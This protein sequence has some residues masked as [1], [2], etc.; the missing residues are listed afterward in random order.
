MVGQ[1]ASHFQASTID[2]NP[3]KL[4]TDAVYRIFVAVFYDD[5]F[6]IFCGLTAAGNLGTR[7]S[8]SARYG[9]AVS[10]RGPSKHRAHGD[11]PFEE[12]SLAAE[13]CVHKEINTMP[14]LLTIFALLTGL[15]GLSIAP[16][17]AFAQVCNPA[18][19]AGFLY[20]CPP[21]A[22][23]LFDHRDFRHFRDDNGFHDNHGFHGDGGEHN[24]GR[25]VGHGGGM[26]HGGGAG[27]GR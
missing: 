23:G 19:A 1:R 12:Y 5:A 20:Q 17:S 27:H 18:L 7:T 24:F 14:K 26:G 3:R 2:T 10:A 11:V 9:S 15:T 21:E 13:R 22:E 6:S 4:C 16:S 25:G 8:G